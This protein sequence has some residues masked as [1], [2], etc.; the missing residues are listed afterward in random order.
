MPRIGC[1]SCG[2]KTKNYVVVRAA[3]GK[4]RYCKPCALAYGKKN[5]VNIGSDP[6]TLRRVA[7]SS[8]TRSTK[9]DK[10]STGAL[11]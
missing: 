7:R 3:G 1:E 8:R 5:W 11:R 4:E 6:A 9:W 10:M 2:K